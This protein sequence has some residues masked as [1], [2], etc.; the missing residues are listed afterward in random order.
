MRHTLVVHSR[1]ED[2]LPQKRGLLPLPLPAA[3][4]HWRELTRLSNKVQWQ[5]FQPTPMQ[6]RVYRQQNAPWAF[7]DAPR[8][9]FT[10]GLH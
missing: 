1:D 9:G 8:I 6:A 7:S 3:P 10:S 2:R 4:A 5:A